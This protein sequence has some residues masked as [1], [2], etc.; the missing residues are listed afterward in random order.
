MKLEDFPG[1]E[2]EYVPEAERV[3]VE[4]DCNPRYTEELGADFWLMQ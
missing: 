3:E 2:N 4:G 1:R